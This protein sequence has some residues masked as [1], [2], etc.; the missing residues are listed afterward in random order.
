MFYIVSGELLRGGTHVDCAVGNRWD[1]DGALER[2]EGLLNSVGLPLMRG[3]VSTLSSVRA[4]ALSL[5]RSV[6]AHAAALFQSL[7]KGAWI[8][9]SAPHA[10]RRDRLVL[11][12]KDGSEG[13]VKASTKGNKHRNYELCLSISRRGSGCLGPRRSSW[14]AAAWNSSHERRCRVSRS[15]HA[16]NSWTS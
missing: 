6:T 14:E 4:A 9:R 15:A 5:L 10:G 16:L 13:G 1:G 11:V 8:L 3:V 2:V 12:R 7:W